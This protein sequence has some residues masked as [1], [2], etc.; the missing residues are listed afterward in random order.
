MRARAI[1]GD[2]SC[3]GAA[4]ESVTST[5]VAERDANESRECVS[6]RDH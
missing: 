4:P 3:E 2:L 5:R 6:R 1:P